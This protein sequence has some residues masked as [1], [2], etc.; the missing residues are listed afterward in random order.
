[1]RILSIQSQVVFGHVG[2]SAAAF[3]L[4]CLG[5][6]V[7]AVPTA[8]FSNHAGYPD[9][10]GRRLSPEEI[11]DL[12]AGL[13]RRGVLAGCGLVISGYLGSAEVA[14]VV[15]DAV[16]RI[17][18]GNP[19][20]RYCCDPVLGDRGAG[21]YV[22]EDLPGAFAET[23]LPL[24][25]ILTPNLFELEVLTGRAPGSLEGVSLD[26][27]AAAGRDCQ[28]RMSGPA[29]VLIT[30]VVYAGLPENAE[31]MMAIDG[32]GAWLVE[33]P[34]LAFT[35]HPHGAG[36]LAAALFA[37]GLAGGGDCAGVLERTAATVHGVLAETARRDAAELSLVESRSLFTAPG[38]SFAARRVG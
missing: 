29:C 13:E 16:A 6:E 38:V 15:A 27:I 36:D 23:L 5:H 10:G 12:F 32:E 33:M 8:V 35:A 30:S 21:V 1:M 22:D 34:R 9:M 11:A 7:L 26:S 24:A 4:A 31:A 19:G 37:A 14:P 2:N 3:A 28:A 25:G 17:R 20:V 18:T